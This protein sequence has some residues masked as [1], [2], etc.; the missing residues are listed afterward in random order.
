MIRSRSGALPAR[1]FP[2]SIRVRWI[3]GI[4]FYRD[5]ESVVPALI[6]RGGTDPCVRAREDKKASR[7]YQ[8]G[9]SGPCLLTLFTQ[10]RRRSVLT[11]W[12]GED[13]PVGEGKRVS[14]AGQL[15]VMTTATTR[16]SSTSG[17]HFLFLLYSAKCREGAFSEVS[18]APV[19]DRGRTRLVRALRSHMPGVSQ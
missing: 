5:R 14:R 12:S 18:I 10:P 8:Q 7:E 6:I 17:W 2:C 16:R 13:H 9:R 3:N 1:S 11:P 4:G 19:V 15:S